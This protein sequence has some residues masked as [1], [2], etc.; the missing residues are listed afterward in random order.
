MTCL[1]IIATELSTEKTNWIKAGGYENLPTSKVYLI[2][3]YYIVTTAT[4]VGYGDISA[5]ND[6]EMFFAMVFMIIGQLAL[7]YGIS[8]LSSII[9]TFDDQ[10]SHL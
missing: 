9:A 6:V 1:W 5:T 10:N 3:T 8:Q 4:T 2:S 7:A